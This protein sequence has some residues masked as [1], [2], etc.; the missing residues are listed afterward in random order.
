MLLN[1][2]TT[3]D[4]HFMLVPDCMAASMDARRLHGPLEF[5]TRIDSHDYPYPELWLRVT[6]EIDEHSFAILEPAVGK[7]L[8]ELECQP[9]AR[10]RLIPPPSV[11]SPRTR[12]ISAC[13]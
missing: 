9:S 13:S 12:T 8:M 7:W 3:A 4:G 11:A 10:G 6:A 2:Y 1:V 5:C